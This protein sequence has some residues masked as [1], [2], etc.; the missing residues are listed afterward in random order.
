M[1]PSENIP[2]VEN[3]PESVEET[4]VSE[5]FSEELLA[6][7][8]PSV[9]EEI[10]A[11]VE[12][13]EPREVK[14]EEEPVVETLTE[15]EVPGDEVAPSP[16]E[17]PAPL[18]DYLVP[19]VGEPLVEEE[20]GEAEVNPEEPQPVVEGV[21]NVTPEEPC[22]VCDLEEAA[23]PVEEVVL[24]EEVVP[25]EEAEI[26][27]VV[28]PVEDSVPEETEEG[29]S[30]ELELLEPEIQIEEKLSETEVE[31]PA[32]DEKFTPEEPTSIEI[33][34]VE[35]EVVIEEEESSAAG[36]VASL[37]QKALEPFYGKPDEEKEIEK[38]AEPV[39][40]DSEVPV[41]PTIADS[42]V[43]VEPVIADSEVPVE[44]VIADSE[45]PV[46]PVIADSE[47]LVEPVIGDSELPVEPVILPTVVE[48]AVEA[49][50]VVEDE[51]Q[52]VEEVPAVTEEV[53]LVVEK[54]SPSVEA[55][56]EDLEAKVLS[57]S[58]NL[59]DSLFGEFK[60]QEVS[61]LKI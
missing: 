1:D 3:T 8:V 57:Q 32:P 26:V 48:D 58:E 53:I 50:V 55:P 21:D 54:V 2:V 17:D 4:V 9:A 24:V 37:F 41:E 44:P 10:I 15:E 28:P 7:V 30:A 20:K 33:P 25:V 11:Y 14:T 43:L 36:F 35:E 39:I 45:L 49:T 51:V 40:V 19:V 18:S 31:I 27:E 6:D 16:I 12:P 22:E 61:V 29:I 60:K 59:A 42:E 13:S 23:D 47:V 38:E 5:V 34:V 56:K 46:E 52:V